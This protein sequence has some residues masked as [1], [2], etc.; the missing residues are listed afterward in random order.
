ME[1]FEERLDAAIGAPHKERI[2]SRFAFAS[3]L[4]VPCD[5]IRI[6]RPP[7]GQFY[8]SAAQ[9]LRLAY[10][11]LDACVC[12]SAELDTVPRGAKLNTL[13]TS[14]DASHSTEFWNDVTRSA[15]RKR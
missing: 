5:D 6:Y 14:P 8:K 4:F 1:G 3:F 2:G 15:A 9:P 13:S 11:K 12:A 7:F 10:K